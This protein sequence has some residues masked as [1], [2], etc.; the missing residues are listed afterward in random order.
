VSSPS[1]EVQT[2]HSATNRGTKLSDPSEG[3]LRRAYRTGRPGKIV[4]D[5]ITGIARAP[6]A[7]F[8]PRLPDPQKPDKKTDEALSVNVESSLR[9]AG[10]PLTWGANASTQYVARITVG[11]CLAS[12]L[13]AYKKPLPDNP[14]HGL[15]W[16][17]VEMASNDRDRYER[18]LDALA[19]ASTMVPDEP[20]LAGE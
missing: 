18:A 12:D 3:L 8:E 17:L 6:A 20:L 4:I 10:L 2:S 15:V 14:H 16:G 5:Q 7:A 13:E 1:N 9:T 19:R 11:D